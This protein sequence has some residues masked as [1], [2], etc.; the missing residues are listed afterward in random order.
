MDIYP[1]SAGISWDEDGSGRTSVCPVGSSH[2]EEMGPVPSGDKCN[3]SMAFVSL[4]PSLL[5]LFKYC[6]K[7]L[8][9]SNLV[10]LTLH[11]F[12]WIVLLPSASSLFLLKAFHSNC[13]IPS[14]LNT[15]QF[16][17]DQ[18]NIFICPEQAVLQL[19]HFL[20]ESHG[21]VCFPGRESSPHRIKMREM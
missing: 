18:V 9:A 2:G 15:L 6:V 5:T 21:E 7:Y 13:P 4:P 12:L 16:Q 8:Q 17:Q 10:F 3:N 19:S 14:V 20:P 1:L 11:P